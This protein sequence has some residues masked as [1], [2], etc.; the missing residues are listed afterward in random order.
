MDLFLDSLKASK[1]FQENVKLELPDQSTLYI[2]VAD[3]IDEIV[4]VKMELQADS[5][6]G[7]FSQIP[8][9][10]S[11]YSIYNLRSKHWKKT[12]KL[13]IQRFTRVIVRRACNETHF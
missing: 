8:L 13:I 11:I 7:I 6:E 9:A 3:P 5:D 4:E 10:V 12:Q 1:S 2:N